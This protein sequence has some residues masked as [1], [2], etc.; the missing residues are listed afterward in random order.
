MEFANK[1]KRTMERAGKKSVGGWLQIGVSSE[2][3]AKSCGFWSDE[4]ERVT[5]I[6][7]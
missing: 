4:N 1:E 7:G 5:N 2:Y 3:E 6:V